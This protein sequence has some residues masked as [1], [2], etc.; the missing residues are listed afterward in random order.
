MLQF[1][2][3]GGIVLRDENGIRGH[4]A[5]KSFRFQR[6]NLQRF[7]QGHTVQFHVDD[8]GSVIRIEQDIDPASCRRCV[9][10]IGFGREIL[11]VMGTFE[12]AESST[13]PAAS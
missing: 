5:P 11:S 13:G 4:R 7:F 10:D 1:L 2:A 12:M 8:P 3:F 9:N 6:D